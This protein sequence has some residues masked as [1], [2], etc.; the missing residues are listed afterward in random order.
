[1]TNTY[2]HPWPSDLDWDDVEWDTNR[3]RG[4]D[5]DAYVAPASYPA[6]PRRKAAAPSFSP[7]AT[8]RPSAQ[9][10]ALLV[11]DVD[12]PLN[13]FRAALSSLGA[14]SGFREVAFRQTVSY[15]A[16]S[17]WSPYSRLHLSRSV[18]D[19]L[20]AFSRDHDVELVWGSLWEHNCNAVVGPA[21]GLPRLPWIDFHGHPVRHLWKFPAVAEFAAGRPMAWLD[22]SFSAKARQRAASGFDRTRRNLPTLLREVDPAVGVL[23]ADLDEVASWLRTARLAW[24]G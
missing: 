13:P 19:T 23:A 20:A 2:R 15:R 10:T 22:D 24:A 14:S 16:G 4:Y 3:S 6:R 8:F 12:G 1:M 9:P 7:R 5:W 21:L 17:T 18:G 11:L